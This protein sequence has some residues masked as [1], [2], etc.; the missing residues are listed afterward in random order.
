MFRITAEEFRTD[1]ISAAKLAILHG[2]IE[3]LEQDNIVWHLRGAAIKLTSPEKELDKG[4][5]HG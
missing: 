4:G 5:F 3:I 2:S 1:P